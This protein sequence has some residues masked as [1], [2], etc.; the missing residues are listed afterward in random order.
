ML[1]GDS[2]SRTSVLVTIVT[3]NH[4]QYIKPCLESILSQTVTVRIKLIDNGSTDSTLQQARSVSGV[5]IEA[6]A[7]NLGFSV[8]HNRLLEG[9]DFEFALLLNPDVVLTPDYL[10]LV[11]MNVNRYPAVGLAGGKLLRMDERGTPVRKEGAF[12]FD[13]TGIYF[14]PQQRHF[15][16]GSNQPDVG[17]YDRL[18]FVFGITGAAVVVRKSLYDDLLESQGEFLDEDFFAYR[19]DADLSWRARLRGWEALYVPDALAFHVRKVLPEKRRSVDSQINYHSVKNRFLMR[20]KNI[21]SSVFWRCFPHMWVR[22]IGIVLYILAKERSSIAAWY[23]LR[24]LR[25]KYSEKRSRIQTTRKIR[26]REIAWWFSYSP[27]S[28]SLV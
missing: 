23:E 17:Q 20:W 27:K 8:A 16:R 4:E 7:T 12:V 10:E 21:D 11:L 2:N 1:T 25:A 6:S 15:D 9:E 19:E 13:S 22:D 5:E 28:R 26:G 18:E 24:R 3:H 14:T